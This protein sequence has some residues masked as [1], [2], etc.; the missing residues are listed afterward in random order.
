M[1]CL[2][3]YY[4]SRSVIFGRRTVRGA[5]SFIAA[6]YGKSTFRFFAPSMTSTEGRS[7]GGAGVGFFTTFSVGRGRTRLT[8]VVRGVTVV[9]FLLIPASGTGIARSPSSSDL[10]L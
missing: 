5:L 9:S 3:P 4:E 10:L 1:P 8:V 7:G 6:D 2:S